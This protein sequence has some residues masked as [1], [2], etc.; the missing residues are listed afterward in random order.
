[1]P[2]IWLT[3]LFMFVCL[4]A[5]AFFSGSELGVPSSLRTWAWQMVAPASKAAWVLSTCSG[6]VIGTAGLSA[7]VGTE[8]VIATQMMQGLVMSALSVAPDTS[9][10][11]GQKWRHVTGQNGGFAARPYCAAAGWRASL[12]CAQ[13]CPSAATSASRSASEWTGDGVIRNRSVPLGTVG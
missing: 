8:P 12:H 5:E 10:V 2:D 11:L 7:L 6:T 4:I 1:M 3:V 9:R 13:S